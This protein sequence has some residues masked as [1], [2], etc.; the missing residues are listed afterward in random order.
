VSAVRKENDNLELGTHGFTLRL[1]TTARLAFTR[2]SLASQGAPADPGAFVA[3]LFAGATRNDNGTTV[4]GCAALDALLCP[5]VGEARGC[6]LAACAAGLIAL[7]HNL[8][9]GFA[10]MDGE[11]I[12]FV[13]QG[14]VPVIDTDGDGAAD[15][16]GRADGDPGL[17]SGEVRG[18]GGPGPVT[19]TWTATRVR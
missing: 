7:Q 15:T 6:L 10:A 11:D 12:D 2:S 19:G 14:T 18:R 13:L 16:L 1:G 9:A 4:T 5:D 3:A 8:D 17:W